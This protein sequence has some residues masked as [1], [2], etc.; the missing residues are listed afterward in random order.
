M[1]GEALKRTGKVKIKIFI[2]I[3]CWVGFGAGF[4][5]G[6][7]G[8]EEG[9]GAGNRLQAGDGPVGPGQSP[10]EAAAPFLQDETRRK[11]DK[12]EQPAAP[13]K[14]GPLKPFEPTEKV[15]ADQALDFPADI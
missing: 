5:T 11:P 13:L 2:F 15:R 8:A 4:T 12:K 10:P 7:L 14:S 3:I 1:R 9:D 6:S